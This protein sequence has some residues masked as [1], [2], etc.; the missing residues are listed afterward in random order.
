MYAYKHRSIQIFVPYSKIEK[1]YPIKK[2]IYYFSHLDVST[3]L[4]QQFPVGELSKGGREGEG[5][6]EM[7]EKKIVLYMIDWK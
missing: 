6:G 7:R 2:L 1:I 3:L 5:R 4:V